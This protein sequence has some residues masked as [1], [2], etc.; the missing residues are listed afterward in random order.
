MHGFLLSFCPSVIYNLCTIN[1]NTSKQRVD[2]GIFSR[3]NS[4]DATQVNCSKPLCDGPFMTVS[5]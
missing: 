5:Y 3:I 1:E 2:L 4:C